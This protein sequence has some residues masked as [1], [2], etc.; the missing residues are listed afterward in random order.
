MTGVVHVA[1]IAAPMLTNVAKSFTNGFV[2][3]VVNTANH[4]NIVQASTN[5]ADTNWFPLL[6]NFPSTNSFKFTDT[7][8]A[9]FSN[10]FYRVMQ[11]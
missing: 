8:T 3:T 10:R 2:F 5:L 7:N 11:P 9:L 6:T 4:T 1:S